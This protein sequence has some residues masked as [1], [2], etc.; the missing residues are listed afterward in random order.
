MHKAEPP[1]GRPQAAQLSSVLLVRF[2][3]HQDFRRRRRRLARCLFLRTSLCSKAD[4]SVSQSVSQ[5]GTSPPPPPMRPAGGPAGG[6]A[7]LRFLPRSP[8]P[9]LLTQARV[10]T[11]YRPSYSTHLASWSDTNNFA[12]L[13]DSCEVPLCAR[14]TPCTTGWGRRI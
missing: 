8:T 12:I 7:G 4:Q 1:A 10:S 14:T 13:L 9:Y 2:S 3:L 6:G 11:V 5:S